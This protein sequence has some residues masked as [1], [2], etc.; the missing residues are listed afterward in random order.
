M[1]TVANLMSNKSGFLPTACIIRTKIQRS[2]FCW[3][4]RL[5]RFRCTSSLFYVQ[6]L[7]ATLMQSWG[8]WIPN[9]LFPVE[10]SEFKHFHH[11][12]KQK[13]ARNTLVRKA[14]S[15]SCQFCLIICTDVV[16]CLGAPC[17]SASLILFWSL[18]GA[19]FY[20]YIIGG[21]IAQKEPQWH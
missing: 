13:I 3:S 20:H 7:F 16:Q 21:V 4:G 5:M 9:G 6:V 15:P 10:R 2:L 12:P 18:P 1:G 19:M 17:S 11:E 14:N 8:C